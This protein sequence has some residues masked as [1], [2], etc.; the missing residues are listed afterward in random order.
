[1]IF[2]TSKHVPKTEK[3]CCV[4]E[5][6]SFRN[7]TQENLPLLQTAET[8]HQYPRQNNSLKQVKSLRGKLQTFAATQS[9]LTTA[10]KYDLSKLI[11]LAIN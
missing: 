9:T 4:F 8:F 10:M 6:N 7:N 5:D 1:M 2:E 11:E 3:R